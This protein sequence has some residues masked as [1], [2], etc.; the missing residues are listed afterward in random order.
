MTF[1]DGYRDNKQWAYPILKRAGVPFAIYVATGFADRLGKLWWLALEQVIARNA[2]F[3]LVMNGRETHFDCADVGAKVEAFEKLYWWL[4]G[5]PSERALL[6]TIDDLAARYGV[7][8]AAFCAEQCM[9]WREIGELARDPL[10]D[11]RGAHRQ[12]S[13]AGQGVGG[14]RAHRA[15]DEPRRDRGRARQGA[16]RISPIRTAIRPPRGRA[17][18]ASPPSS[19]SRPR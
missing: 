3:A 6:A 1:D 11:H 19:A 2:R 18:S 5:L 10:V 13:D 16:R 15:Q 12:P 8:M 9:D 4:R 14:R 7:D 17:N